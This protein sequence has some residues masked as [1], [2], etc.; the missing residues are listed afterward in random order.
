MA[1]FEKEERLQPRIKKMQGDHPTLSEKQIRCLI[2]MEDGENEET[3]KKERKREKKRL[4]R[5]KGKDSSAGGRVPDNATAQNPTEMPMETAMDADTTPSQNFHKEPTQR[6]RGRDLYD[7]SCK[8]PW[9]TANPSNSIVAQHLT[10]ATN[11][12]N[13]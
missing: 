6:Q 10:S 4:A 2:K 9:K 3:N 8:T 1:E 7:G 12:E 13:Y 11:H 5:A